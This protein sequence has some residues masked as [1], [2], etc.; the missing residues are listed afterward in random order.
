M[1]VITTVEAVPSRVRAVVRVVAD[2]GP[3]PRDEVISCLMPGTDKDGMAAK[4]INETEGLKLIEKKGDELHLSSNVRRGDVS[5][6]RADSFL[7]DWCDRILIRRAPQL[8]DDNGQVARA[9]SWFLCQSPMTPLHWNQHHK[10]SWLA[11][12]EGDADYNLSNASR[13]ANLFYWAHY[14]GYASSIDADGPAANSSI[15]SPADAPSC[16]KASL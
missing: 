4:C 14:L 5:D 2:I 16:R 1:S 15:S 13:F 6:A 9:F 7:R 10:A 11:V 12:V 8:D 3:A